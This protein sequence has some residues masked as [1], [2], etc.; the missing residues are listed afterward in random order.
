MPIELKILALGALLLFVHIFTAT[1]F[2]TS[3]I[4]PQVECRR[5]RRDTARSRPA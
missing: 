1:R 4:W 2:K 3:A 5:A